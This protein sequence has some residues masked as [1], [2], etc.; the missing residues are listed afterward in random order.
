MTPGIASLKF[1][2]RLSAQT[3]WSKAK[4]AARQIQ[5]R[6]R[7]LRMDA[8]AASSPAIEEFVHKPLDLSQSNI[9]LLRILPGR[10]QD[11]IRC[12]LRHVSR[13][14]HEYVCLSYTWGDAE[15]SHTILVNQKSFKVRRNLW[16]FL[17]LARRFK[18]QDRLWIDAM[19]IDQRNI[20]ERNHQV[21][22]TTS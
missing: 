2:C 16:D 11:V 18:V 22:R 21:N 19:C 13:H 6:G 7:R 15:P 1:R 4:S 20:L 3:G 10:Q 8:A 14:K 9:R 17:C 5:A 12:T